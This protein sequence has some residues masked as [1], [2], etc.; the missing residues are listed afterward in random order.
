MRLLV[1]RFRA[2]ARDEIRNANCP[3]DCWMIP[4]SCNKLPNPGAQEGPN[5]RRVTL[6]Y[7]F[8]LVTREGL[9]RARANT[10][11]QVS[12]G[13]Y[14][15]DFR[16]FD[17]NLSGGLPDNLR[18]GTILLDTKGITIPN[19]EDGSGSC[20]INFRPGILSEGP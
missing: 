10:A 8:Y 12:L 19:K 14:Q 2:N 11:P 18:Y 4:I 13:G 1:I 7:V 17:G 16:Y 5:N 3:V 6:L 20:L 15:R 9:A